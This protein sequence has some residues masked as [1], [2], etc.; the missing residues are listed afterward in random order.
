MGDD[1]ATLLTLLRREGHTGAAVQLADD[2]VF[3]SP[4]ADYEGS[5]DVLHLL[6]PIAS[7]LEDVRLTRSIGDDRTTTSFVSAHVGGHALTG[8]LD[9]ARDADGRVIV[10][11]LLLR[12]YAALRTAMGAMQA[13]LER[14]P[15]PS[16][17]RK[18]ASEPASSAQRDKGERFRALHKGEPFVIANPYDVGSAR[19][20]AALGCRALA[21]TSSGFAFTLGRLDGEARLH[22][23]L[24]HTRAIVD[25]TA[26]PVSVDL[27]NGYGEAPEVVAAAI[28]A[29][30]A[31][32]A[33]GGSIEDFDR[34]R[35]GIYPRELAAERIA[36]A[37]DAAR[38]LDFP[39]TLTARAENHIRGRPDLDDTI[40]RLR[41]FERAG[42]DVLF[43]PGLGIDEL[44]AVRSATRLPLNA[45]AR[46]SLD[47]AGLY[48]AGVQRVSVGGALTWVAVN[49]MAD[50]AERVL[51]G[52]LAA[53]G[54]GDQ[55]RLY[56]LLATG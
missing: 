46:P 5:E 16:T 25:A 43:A 10:A 34:D 7:V 44:R 12:P 39:F 4:V 41:A 9:E 29:V 18:G 31:T 23:V 48:A 38:S 49:A 51:R 3:H 54:A 33:V 35:D 32:G 14:D 19:I 52:D 2:V 55:A 42:A 15:L 30:A 26:L 20:L 56:A 11:T 22:E 40:D 37:A 17:R 8:V 36:A 28:R 24:A 45:L 1:A 27:E 47:L 21:T 50:A 53:L 13:A 6:R